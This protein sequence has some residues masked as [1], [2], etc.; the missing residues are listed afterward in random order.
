[1]KYMNIL[2]LV[3]LCKI[4]IWLKRN[5]FLNGYRHL[6]C[7]CN[8]DIAKDVET[9]FGISYLELNGSLTTEKK[10]NVICERPIRCTNQ[11]GICRIKSTNI[12]I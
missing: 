9:R 8:K 5:T 3:W 11:E 7:S 1:M 10:G 2:I 6:H 4:I 12:A